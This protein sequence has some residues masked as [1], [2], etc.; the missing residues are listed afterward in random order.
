MMSKFLLL[1]WRKKN[2]RNLKNILWTHTIRTTTLPTPKFRLTTILWRH[3]THATHA[4]FLTHAKILWTHATHS[5]IL[6]HSTHAF[7]LTHA[8][9]LQIHA[10]HTKVWP[11]PPTNPRT[12][13][14]HATHTI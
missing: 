10:T 7:F 3:F 12:Y 14:T 11:T 13:A 8:K 4:I 5:K 1:L 9:I 6:T 2:D